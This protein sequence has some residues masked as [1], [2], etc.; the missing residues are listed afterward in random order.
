MSDV[1]EIST[2]RDTSSSS[3]SSRV[4]AVSQINTRKHRHLLGMRY[5]YTWWLCLIS[6][7]T[8]SLFLDI[9][10]L[11]TNYKHC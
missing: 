6:S 11:N 2:Q 10:H 5:Y 4:V 8:C 1:F 7:Y 3:S 9:T